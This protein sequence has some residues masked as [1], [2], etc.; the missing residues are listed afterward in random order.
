LKARKVNS[1][2]SGLSSTSRIIFSS[3]VFSLSS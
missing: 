2:S 3:M 1:T